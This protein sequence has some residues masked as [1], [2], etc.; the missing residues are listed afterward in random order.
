MSLSIGLGRAVADL[1]LSFKVGI[2]FA[3]ILVVTV[4]LGLASRSGI[5]DVER[6]FDGFSASAEAA[7]HGTNVGT[8]FALALNFVFNQTSAIF[9]FLVALLS[10]AVT[11]VAMLAWKFFTTV[12]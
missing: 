4:A 5:V 9:S 6:N 11:G 2:G 10:Q 1:K 3:S 12:Q 8:A 7:E